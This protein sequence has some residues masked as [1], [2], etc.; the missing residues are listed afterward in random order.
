MPKYSCNSKN[1]VYRINCLIC[2][3]FYIG[4]TSRTIGIRFSEHVRALK[5][6]DQNNPIVE[7]F[8]NH[9]FN[10]NFSIENISLNILARESNPL[11]TSIC[12]SQYISSLQP[13]MNRKFERSYI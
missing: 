10:F 1:V 2:S 4:K 3:H 7:H 5:K 8:L 12:E 6:K 11:R 9:H 13:E